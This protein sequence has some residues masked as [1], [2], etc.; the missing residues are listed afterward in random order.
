M[1]GEPIEGEAKAGDT[2]TL[3]ATFCCGWQE[4]QPTSTKKALSFAKSLTFGDAVIS[5]FDKLVVGK[6]EGD[7]FTTTIKISEDAANEDYRG[8]EVE[9]EFE[10]HEIRRI[11]SQ[12]KSP[13]QQL[14]DLG[15]DKCR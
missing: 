3:N 14:D 8:K 13:Q 10:I 7:K 9:A 1:T 6:K 5:D 12:T 4:N 2:V 15:F 11:A